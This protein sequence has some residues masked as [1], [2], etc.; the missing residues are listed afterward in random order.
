MKSNS[1]DGENDDSKN[2]TNSTGNPSAGSSGTIGTGGC[3]TTRRSRNR[4]RHHQHQQQQR[5]QQQR[6]LSGD[7]DD[8]CGDGKIVDDAD[9]G[10]GSVQSIW[11]AVQDARPILPKAAF[12]L[13]DLRDGIPMV[14]HSC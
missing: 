3:R 11:S 2:Y 7:V 12:F 1:F 13:G 14:R 10:N 8:G 6:H 5:H 4:S 9:D